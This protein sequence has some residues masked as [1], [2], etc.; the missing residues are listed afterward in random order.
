M[1]TEFTAAQLASPDI[2]R[3]DAVIRS[4][5]HHGFCPQT[6]PTYLLLGDENDSPRGRIRLMRDMLE[7][8]G[9]PD[10]DTVRHLDRCL[11]CLGCES[12]CAARLDYRH[13]VDTARQHIEQHFRRP[14]RERWLRALLA[15]LLTKPNRLRI[16]LALG[17]LAAPLARRLPGRLGTLAALAAVRAPAR[18]HVRGRHH[19]AEGARRARVALLPGCVQQVLGAA[20][21]DAAVRLLTR[22]GIEVVV[23]DAVE[24]CGALTL[25]M[26]RAGDARAAARR[27]IVAC[28]AALGDG[29]LDAVVATASGCGTTL[30]DY[31]TQF[32]DEPAWQARAAAVAALARDVSEVLEP[33][34]LHASETFPEVPVAYHDACSLQHGQRV[35]APP[36]A[37]LRA[38]GFDVR[39]LREG[40][41]CCGSA[42]TYN[43][44]QP[45]LA[46]ELGARKARAADASGAAVLAAGNLGCLVQVARYAAL[47]AVHTVELLDWATGG[48]RP[49]ALAGLDTSAWPP[50]ATPPPAPA[51]TD[52]INFWAY[53][54]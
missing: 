51:A 24:C 36:R 19:P 4:C 29:G 15:G 1:K 14:W 34:A 9:P 26:G 39:E 37:L 43:L 7:Q 23:L 25:H 10:P 38:A 52:A 5:V 28:E 47:P 45:A 53:E 44:L 16:A 22:H 2:A 8:G 21:N 12:T 13:L 32:A 18:A 6:C 41:L 27:A 20:V 49:A 42:G 3:A 54:P 40:H 30:K 31:A 46:A 11:S 50:R 48:P 35:S 33:D 17:R